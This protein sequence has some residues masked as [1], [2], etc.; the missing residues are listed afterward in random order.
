ME[1]L[2]LQESLHVPRLATGCSL[3]GSLRGWGLQR[4]ENAEESIGVPRRGRS[5]WFS[6]GFLDG[7]GLRD[8]E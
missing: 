5:S 1:G 4:K 2:C 7:G 8:P 6:D 3:D